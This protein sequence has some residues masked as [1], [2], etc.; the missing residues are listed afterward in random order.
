MLNKHI[1]CTSFK[2]AALRIIVQCSPDW[3]TLVLWQRVGA[4]G[5]VDCKHGTHTSCRVVGEADITTACT[6]V[7]YCIN[8]FITILLFHGCGD[9]TL[10]N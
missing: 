8:L 3:R 6:F 9:S 10:L 5:V 7:D 4:G 1:A 2:F